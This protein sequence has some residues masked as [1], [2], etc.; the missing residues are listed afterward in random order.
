MTAWTLTHDGDATLL[1]PARGPA[2]WDVAVQRSIPATTNTPRFRS[3]MA[4][5]IRQD[6]WR[7]AARVRGFVPMV[8]VTAT[9][10]ALDLTAGGCL[11]TK[12]GH[13]PTLEAAISAILDNRTTRDRWLRHAA[14]TPNRRRSPCSRKS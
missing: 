11:H 4:A 6:I 12:S 7:A 13:R 1:T 14:R 3:R 5:Q 8:R 2:R 10:D 9:T